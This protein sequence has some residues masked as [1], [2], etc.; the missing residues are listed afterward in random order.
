MKPEALLTGRIFDDRPSRLAWFA[1]AM[2][3][4]R[5]PLASQAS[6][7]LFAMAA[8]AKSWRRES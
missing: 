8:F 1:S 3:R 6:R 2:A 4:A 5:S 7:R